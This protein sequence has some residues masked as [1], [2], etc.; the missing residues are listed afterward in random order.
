[1]PSK[2]INKLTDAKIRGLAKPKERT[3]LF[4]GGT[5]FGLRLEPSGT[6]SFVVW[7]RFNGKQDGVTLG[8]YPKLS[9]SDARARVIKIK[10]KIE[11][12]E[13]PKIEIKKVQRANKSF[14]T[15]E[16]LCDEYII[17][18]AKVNKRS[19]R[20]DQRILKKD[21]LPIWRRRKARDITKDDV[22]ALLDSIVERGAE[23][24]ANRTLS[25]VRK[26]FNFAFERDILKWNEVLNPCKGVKR[27]LQ[28]ENERTRVLGENEIKTLW[29]QL[30]KCKAIDRRIGLILKLMLLTAQ[31][32]VECLN[33][34]IT[35]IDNGWW[36]IPQEISKNKKPHR[37]FLSPQAIEIISLAKE[38][39][40]ESDLVFPS[41]RTGRAFLGSSI[42]HALRETKVQ[43]VIKVDFTP[44]DL[45]RTAS[46][47]MA[48]MG[49]PRLTVSKILNHAEAGVTAKHYDHYA[50]DKE[51]QE[52]LTKWG[53]RVAKICGEKQ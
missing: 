33:L 46:T 4:E 35:D 10:Q 16:D 15:V 29:S 23:I 53:K 50:Y 13:D 30:D 36:T 1:M 19:W 37:V 49:I 40:P 32:K 11:R 8:R 24:Q 5:G 12:G 6:K 51:K 38:L 42:D 52:A 9:L 27:P 44:H 47:T 7:Y 2:T 22:I 21:I 41:P 45:R 39:L 18:H 17:R 20:E 3:F 31:R 48:S 43:E 25:I 28:K 14:Y 26:M 34:K